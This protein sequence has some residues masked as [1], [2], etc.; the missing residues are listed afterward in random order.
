M[1]GHISERLFSQ[2]KTEYILCLYTMD[3]YNVDYVNNIGY[4][5]L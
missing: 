4:D 3:S 2:I 1:G 5:L